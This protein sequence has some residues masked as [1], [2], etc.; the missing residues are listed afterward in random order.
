VEAAVNTAKNIV[1][2]PIAV[3]G[4]RARLPLARPGANRYASDDL[5]VKSLAT[6]RVLPADRHLTAPPPL[7]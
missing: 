6:A 7:R 1:T 4:L 3:L 2:M 5:A